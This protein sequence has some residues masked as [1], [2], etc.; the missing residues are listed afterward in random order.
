MKCLCFDVGG[1]SIKYAIIEN[2]KIGKISSIPTRKTKTSNNI[3]DDIIS[4]CTN[5]KKIDAIGVCTAGV[6]D[7][8]LGKII[9]SG[10]TIPGYT[11]T[12]IKKIIEEKFNIPCFVENDVNCAA[13][14]EYIYT[15]SPD[16][17]FCMTIGTGVGGAFILNDKIYKGNNFMACEIGY[18]PFK[19]GIF[20]DFASTS[21]LTEY[22]SKKLEKKVD[23]LYIFENA[24][25]GDKICKNAINTLVKN[26]T[27]GI[28]NVIY[29]LNPSKIIIGG[30]IT[31]QKEYLEPLIIK[32]VNKKIIN[33]KFST[34]IELATLEN[35]AGL[36][37]IYYIIR[38]EL[39]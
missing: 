38:K 36:F 30:G 12:K 3:L 21:F 16:N 35:N 11:G 15:N 1:T 39:K 34:K 9:F 4:I 13:Y 33:K 22:V 18:M 27:H 14:G 20:Q 25:K 6:V 19:K 23:G 17:M 28:L 2:N 31:A 8:D 29:T 5:Y 37:G 26:L 24:K 7:S 32:N 10:P